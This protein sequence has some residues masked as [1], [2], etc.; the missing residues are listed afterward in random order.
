MLI[1]DDV[2]ATGGHGAAATAGWSSGWAATVAGLAFVLEL[3]F[4]DGRGEL[5]GHDVAQLVTCVLS[6]LTKE[7][8]RWPPS[9]GSCPGGATTAPP[10]DEVAP[11]LAAYRARHPKAAD[12]ADHPGLRRVAPTPTRARPASRASRTSATRWPWPRSWPSSASTTSP[13]AAALLHDAVEDTGIT[14][15]DIE[16]DFGADVA[17]IVD[18]VTKLDRIQ[19]DSKEAQQAATMRKMLVAMAKDLRVL[20]I[21]LADRLTTCARSPRMPAW[22][23]ER[24]AQETLDIYAP[25]AHRLGMQ[26]IKQQL[27]DLAFAA[28]HPKRYAEID[29]MVSTR[30][31]ERDLYLDAG[32]RGG[33]PAARRAAH[34]RRGH[35]PAEAPVVASTRRWS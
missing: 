24:T 21:K 27:E 8:A 13:I 16:R 33:A 4:L 12:R 31:P 29:H 10:A 18:G 30:A 11:L 22:K 3:G 17:A 7:A 5:A 1:V 14:L 19:F 23:Q 34:R 9:T 28:L 25:L 6:R 20:I 32:A 26:D 2:L 35:R 15:D